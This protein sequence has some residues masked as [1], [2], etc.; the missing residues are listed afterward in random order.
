MAIP[1]AFFEALP[2][3]DCVPELSREGDLFG[4]DWELGT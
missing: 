4:F 1:H 3:S 2:S